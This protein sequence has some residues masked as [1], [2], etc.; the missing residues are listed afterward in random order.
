M[1]RGVIRYSALPILVLL[2][3]SAASQAQPPA[4]VPVAVGDKPAA[5]SPAPPPPPAHD[6]ALSDVPTIHTDCDSCSTFHW[7]LNGDYL[8]MRPRRRAQDYAIV[9]PSNDGHVAGTIESLDWDHRSGM[10][11]GGGV[12][13]GNSLDAVF[14]YTYLHSE[15]AGSVTAPDGGV[16]FATLTHPGTVDQVT[17]AAAAT[18]FNY[19]VYDFEI[20]KS[21]PVGDSFSMRLFGGSRSARIDQ[22]FNALYDGL[23]ANKDFVSSRVQFMG[24]GVRVGG[25]GIWGHCSGF[26]LY[27]RASA[28]L[29]LGDF[30]THLSENDNAGTTV[31]VDVTERF[32]KVV[33]VLELGVGLTW[34]YEG[35]R[36]SV[37][38]EFTNWFGLADMPNFVDDFHQGKFAHH[39]NDLSIDGLTARLEW[40]Y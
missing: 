33:P 7:I 38:Y 5:V 9:D 3:W 21:F 34:R 22:N 23:T 24:S 6:V 4:P 30:K 32:E 19:N 18:S 29:L 36:V 27:G 15:N 17:S 35:L 40:R 14:L 25:E 12:G 39:I 2:G 31:L 1:A 10:R 26:G 11:V 16:L 13:F 20:G 8:Y 28:S 37:G